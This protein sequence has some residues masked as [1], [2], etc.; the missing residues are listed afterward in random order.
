[1]AQTDDTPVKVLDRELPKTRPRRIWTSVGAGATVYGYTP[2]RK[3]EGPERFLTQYRGYLQADVAAGYDHLEEKPE[4]GLV[5]VGCLAHAR[6]KYFDAR[7]SNLPRVAPA[8]GYIGLLYRIER[9]ARGWSPAERLARRRR[10]A[11]PV[12]EGLPAYLERARLSVL[13]KSPEG[14][15]IG[16]TL[17][18]WKALRRY[19]AD[20]E[21]AIDNNGAERSLRGVA[22]GRRNGMFF[23]SDNGGRT[24][25]VLTSFIASRQQSK[26]EPW[27]YLRD[28]LT[29]IADHPVNALD[30]LLPSSWKPASA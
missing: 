21:L 27:G 10:C 24:A 17:S 8:L 22:V 3:R 4:R 13:P 23:G 12:L 26:V 11:V 19:A 2:T 9:T 15:A 1:V 29:R 7:T 20:G 14:M 5:E 25:A 18:N 16:Y 28:V 30:E 6:R